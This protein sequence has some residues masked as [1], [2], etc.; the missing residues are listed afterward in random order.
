[1]SCSVLQSTS[2]TPHWASPIP[3]CSRPRGSGRYRV[4]TADLEM[5]D[6]QI[7]TIEVFECRFEVLEH[8]WTTMAGGNAFYDGTR[9]RGVSEAA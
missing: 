4:A 7:A 2:R 9:W 3:R 8:R 6:G 5:F 1:M